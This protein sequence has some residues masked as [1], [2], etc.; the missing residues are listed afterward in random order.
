M[1]VCNREEA[2]RVQRHVQLDR[3]DARPDRAGAN[4]SFQ[5]R[6]YLAEDRPRHLLEFLAAADVPAAMDVLD[7]D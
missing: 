7:R 4:A 3:I 1:P 2:E 5:Y 6:G